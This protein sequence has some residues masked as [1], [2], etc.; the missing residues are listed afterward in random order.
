MSPASPGRMIA[1]RP[2]AC[3]RL[4]GR[5]PSADVVA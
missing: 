5:V 4:A 3:T 2:V 1:H